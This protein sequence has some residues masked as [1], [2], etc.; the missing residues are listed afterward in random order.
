MKELQAA[1]RARLAVIRARQKELIKQG[2]KA[3]AA[4]LDP[5]IEAL[6]FALKEM[7]NGLKF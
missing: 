7:K 3:A 4:S 6:L 2:K 1:Y 5:A